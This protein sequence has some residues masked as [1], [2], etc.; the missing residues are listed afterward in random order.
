MTQHSFIYFHFP[1][2]LTGFYGVNYVQVAQKWSIEFQPQI[3]WFLTVP[4][5]F[6][7]SPCYML[8][9]NKNRVNDCVCV[10]L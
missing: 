7:V 2:S 8:I 3:M 5:R 10:F 4:V 1:V 9:I 6:L